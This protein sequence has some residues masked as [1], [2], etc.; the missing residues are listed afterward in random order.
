MKREKKTKKY[1]LTP[2]PDYQFSLLGIVTSQNDYK[3]A[4]LINKELQL[5]LS[6]SPSLNIFNKK[7]NISTEFSVYSDD[8]KL[9]IRLIENKKAPFFL[10][11]QFRHIDFFL[12]IKAG[13]RAYSDL[14]IKKNLRQISEIQA[15]FSL[16]VK[17]LKSKQFF[18]L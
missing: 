2:E 4:W 12:Q 8:N 1:K 18:L 10:L 5:A 3:L 11:P 14:K 15:V 13:D 9:I 6:K 7:Q 16:D 17:T